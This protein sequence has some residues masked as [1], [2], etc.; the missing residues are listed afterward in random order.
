MTNDFIANCTQITF[1]TYE[2]AFC[3]GLSVL[4]ALGVYERCSGNFPWLSFIEEK[5]ENKLQMHTESYCAAAKISFL[6]LSKADISVL[7]KVRKS[8]AWSYL[9]H[10]LIS[11]NWRTPEE[12]SYYELLMTVFSGTDQIFNTNHFISTAGTILQ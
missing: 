1:L 12:D 2:Q 6:H 8:V 10:R 3:I 11:R 7:K 4:M 9:Q 5:N